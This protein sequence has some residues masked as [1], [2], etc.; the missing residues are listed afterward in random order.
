MAAKGKSNEI[1]LIRTYDAP[2][3]A[4]VSA[5]SNGEI[6][7]SNAYYV[8]ASKMWRMTVRVKQR[9]P[10]QPTELRGFLQKGND[11]LTETWSNIVPA[12]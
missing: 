4:V 3:K 9:D 6:V 1:H 5:P 7:E 2:V 12:R 10:K 11:V 8:E